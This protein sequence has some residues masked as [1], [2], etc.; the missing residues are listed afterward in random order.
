MFLIKELILITVILIPASLGLFEIS[1]TYLNSPSLVH[2]QNAE[3]K[4]NDF[5][6][7]DQ[8]LSEEFYHYLYLIQN[9]FLNKEEI[10]SKINS[11]N[12]RFEKE[13]LSAL[14]KKREGNFEEAY[15]QLFLLL[16]GS[17]KQFDYYEDISA[18]GKITGN[19]DKLSNWITV[20]QDSSNYYNLYFKGLIDK[21]KGY[22]TNSISTFQ[23]LITR[24]FA[25]KEIYY[26]L[27]YAL[28]SVGNY[29][30]AFNSLIYAKKLCGKEDAFLAKIINLK[31]TLYFLSGDYDNAKKEYES[32]LE[33]AKQSGNTVEEI[34]SLANLAIIKDQ[35][36][37]IDDARVG[38][39]SAISQAKKIENSELLAF[40]Y[41]E[42]GV[43]YTYTNNLI[44]ARNNYENS[45]SIYKLMK[46][47]ER[48]SYLSANIGALFLQISNYKDALQ[49]YN[50]GLNYAG[51]NKLGKILNLTGIADVY[52]NESNY[53]KALEYYNKAKELAD[54][55]KDI[56]SILKID[57]GIGALYFNINRPL[58]ALESLKKGVDLANENQLPFE[59]VKLYS[60][61]GTVFNSIDSLSQA[62]DY[63]NKGLNIAE[64]T[65]DIY[66][67]I[68]LNTE[69]AYNYYEQDKFSEAEKTLRKEQSITQQYNLTQVLGLQDLYWGKIYSTKKEY[70]KAREKLK[71]A[72]QLSSEANDQNNQIEASYWLAKSFVN[73]NDFDLAEKWFEISI[74]LIE[75]L[76][77]PLSLN[78]EIQITHYSGF[79]EVYNSLTEF[80]LNQGKGEQAFL[81][82]ERSRARNTRLNL[83]KLKLLSDLK[84][85]EVI[86]NLIDI[87]WMV[88]S[89]LYNSQITDSLNQV[90]SKI[91]TEII[92]KNNDIDRILNPEYTFSIKG[93]K[94]SLRPD[95]YYLQ[96]FLGKKFVT[97]FKLNSEKLDVKTL[98]ISPDSLMNLISSISPIYKSG[99]ENQEIYI[100]EDLFSFNALSSYKLYTKVFKDFLASVPENSTLIVSFP[101]ELVK[102]PIE[103]LVTEW[104]EDESPYYYNN[105]KFLLRKYEFVYT[106]S[107]SIYYAQKNKN[108]ENNGHNLLVGNPYVGNTELT[109]SVRTGLIDLNPSAPRSIKMFPLKFSED[110]IKSID[111]TIDNNIVLLS[112]DAT[113]SNF[114][115]NAPNSNIVHISSHSFLIK[116]Q[117]LVM[118][119]PQ[120]DEKDDGFLELGEIV[121][122]GLN[123]ELV[124]LSSC[125]SGL[126]RIDAAEG[127]IGMQKA[128]FEAGSKSVLVTL[129]DVND[130]YTSFFMKI[131][132]KQLASG[133]SKSEALQQTKLEFIQNYSANPFYWSAFVLS[134]NPAAIKLQQASSFS[135]VY[136]IVILLLIAFS[137]FI[138]KKFV[139]FNR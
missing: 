128:F 120:A 76:S 13:Y 43:S 115:K 72:F 134:G 55:I 109:L 4:K 18:L 119:S 135:I 61:I 112:S 108:Q 122:L 113:E 126:G 131:F 41:S 102:L 116:D 53:S 45:Y 81:L 64:E 37:E 89:G 50:E 127:I 130:K 16:N 78:Q 58:I 88:S 111:G 101:A 44:E 114:K 118:F 31:G 117:P 69:L 46:N 5:P 132:Y 79:T 93:L 51:E 11:I 96:V 75:R 123:S 26:Q 95:E 30:D 71:S 38:F 91:K 2:S 90:Y 70:E 24:G 20:N 104:N 32:S 10:K 84:N 28:R 77:Y 25:S 105:K 48:L 40:L 36:G 73:T 137:Y 121:Q 52:S 65:G 14:L 62:E 21:E 68:I 19:L 124:V 39:L 67:A 82:L 103:L 1:K 29:E 35:Y 106:P 3:D 87:Q 63:F 8:K 34:K 83:D 6:N 86:K 60:N 125:R 138:I 133:K 85:D 15:N 92:Q 42:L 9:S 22:T 57:G 97:L 107:V 7:Y 66:S 27:A 129:W 17:P 80:Y 12:S 98:D 100:N 49:Y 74:G 33:F 99:V 139:V 56:P 23:S 110:E 47:N 54:S 136:V 59:L 94:E